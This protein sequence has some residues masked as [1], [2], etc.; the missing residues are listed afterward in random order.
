[1]QP[2]KFRYLMG[3]AFDHKMQTGSNAQFMPLQR[4]MHRVLKKLIK[5]E[6]GGDLRSGEESYGYANQESV[7]M[8]IL[9]IS[10]RWNC[11]F[12]LRWLIDGLD[13]GKI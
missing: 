9:Y 7:G 13:N 4:E 10:D 1:M 5:I 2:R 3:K 8:N 6:D 12:R 11:A